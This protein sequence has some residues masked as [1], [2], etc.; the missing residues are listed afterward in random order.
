M[1]SQ[2]KESRL[3]ELRL[4]RLEREEIVQTLSEIR[5]PERIAGMELP[6]IDPPDIVL[7]SGDDIRRAVDWAAIRVGLRRRRRSPWPTVAGLLVV[8]G[9][10]AV[11]AARTPAVRVQVDRAT[12]KA[13]DRIAQMRAE[14]A[15]I[16]APPSEVG[17]PMT[18]SVT[19]PTR[20]T[21]SGS[22]A[23][24]ATGVGADA[25]G[26]PV[27]VGPGEAS[28]TRNGMPSLEEREAAKPV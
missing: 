3:P 28:A 18:P 20:M 19:E 24:A 17:E 26:K 27:A 14:R 6:R 21:S 11:A 1:P 2:T 13:R 22:L 8:A 12:Q 16:E 4:P 7:P 5:L 23:A 15:V 10:V 9:V 25:P